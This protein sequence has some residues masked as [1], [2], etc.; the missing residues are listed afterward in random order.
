MLEADSENVAL[1]TPR[2]IKKI[3]GLAYNKHDTPFLRQILSLEFTLNVLYFSLAFLVAGYYIGSIGDQLARIGDKGKFVNMFFWINSFGGV[4]I[5]VI[6]LLM[7]KGGLP[8]TYL[9][10]AILQLLFFACVCTEILELQVVSFLLVAFLNVSNG[11]LLY[12]FMPTM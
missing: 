6:G 1:L 11:A 8:L 12:G 3:Q 7:D 9:V 4:T 5:P 10:N 2:K